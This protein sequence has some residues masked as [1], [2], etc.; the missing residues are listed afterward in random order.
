MKQFIYADNAATTQLDSDAFG[1]YVKHK[2]KKDFEHGCG[3]ESAK[4]AAM[5]FGMGSMRGGSRGTINLGGLV[6]L[7]SA[8]KDIGLQ[9]AA[10]N[11]YDKE[12]RRCLEKRKKFL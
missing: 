3:E 8:L 11:T 5:V 10:S 2:V 9:Q 4:A 12:R 6:G 1:L 7:N